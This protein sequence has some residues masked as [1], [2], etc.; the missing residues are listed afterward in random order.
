MRFLTEQNAW[1]AREHLLNWHI[2]FWKGITAALLKAT[3]S[4][5][6]LMSLLYHLH[7][8]QAGKSLSRGLTVK[9]HASVLVWDCAKHHKINHR[10]FK[11][12]YSQHTIQ[13]TSQ[14]ATHWGFANA[15]CMDSESLAGESDEFKHKVTWHTVEAKC[16]QRLKE[17]SNSISVTP[18]Q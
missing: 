13:Q 4:T 11:K 9:L 7:C 12:Q 15:Q 8:N 6:Q 16:E 5:K 2:G 3:L 10:G 14:L 17:V 1:T 18:V